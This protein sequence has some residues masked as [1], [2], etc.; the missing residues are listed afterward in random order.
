MSLSLLSLHPLFELA[1]VLTR[2]PRS[3]SAEYWI[4][5]DIGPVKTPEGLRFRLS[6]AHSAL[7]VEVSAPNIH[8]LLPY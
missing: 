6:K 1:T 8:S 7:L 2:K 5:H 4:Q 3:V